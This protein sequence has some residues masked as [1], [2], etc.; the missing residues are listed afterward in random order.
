MSLEERGQEVEVYQNQQEKPHQH[1]GTEEGE[2]EPRKVN[3]ERRG[4]DRRTQAWSTWRKLEARKGQ[5]LE[6]EGERCDVCDDKTGQRL[7]TARLEDCNKDNIQGN[8]KAD[9]RQSKETGVTEAGRTPG[10]TPG[11][12][13]AT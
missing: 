5:T 8:K 7:W 11:R 12:S 1:S 13:G 2:E 3:G 9:K 10:R 6:N 4:H